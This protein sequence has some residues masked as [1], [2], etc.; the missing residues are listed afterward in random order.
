VYE[1]TTQRQV[2][3]R[4]IAIRTARPLAAIA[5]DLRAAVHTIDPLLALSA[6]MTLDARLESQ[7]VQQRFVRSL[8]TIFAAIAAGLCGLGLFAVVSLTGRARRHEFA[9]RMALGAQHH[10]IAWLVVRQSLL[11]GIVGASIG[12]LA[13]WWVAG[14]LHALLHGVTASDPTTLAAT[15][16]V[17]LGVATVA[18]LPPAWRAARMNP[19]Q[20]LKSN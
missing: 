19:I 20:L 12:L 3:S 11:L 14:I 4:V 7:I 5:A 15:V 8:L 6:P 10:A 16:L 17:I 1:S 9:L 2:L 18:A 13:S